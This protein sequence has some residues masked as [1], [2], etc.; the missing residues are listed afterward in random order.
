VEFFSKRN[1][2]VGNLIGIQFVRLFMQARFH[3]GQSSERLM[4][5]SRSLPQQMEQMRP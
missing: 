1:I 2:P 5:T 3:Q 4:L